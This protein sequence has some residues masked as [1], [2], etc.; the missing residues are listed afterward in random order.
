MKALPLIVKSTEEYPKHRDCFSCHHQAIPVLALATAKDR[1][2]KI[3]AETI[4]VSVDLA[5]ADLQGG[6]ESYKKGSGQ[7]GGVTLRGEWPS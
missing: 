5:E 2:F 6:I 3:E 1:G 7:G 4:G